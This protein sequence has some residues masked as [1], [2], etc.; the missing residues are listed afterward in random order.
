MRRFS[1]L[2]SFLFP[3]SSRLSPPPLEQGREPLMD[4]YL[5]YPEKKNKLMEA[6]FER[7]F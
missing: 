2:N 4:L 7:N 5:S 1:P 6:A 3:L